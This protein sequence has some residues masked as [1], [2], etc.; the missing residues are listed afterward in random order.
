MTPVSPDKPAYGVLPNKFHQN[1]VA[2]VRDQAREKSLAITPRDDPEATTSKPTERGREPQGANADLEADYAE[3]AKG[4]EN[5]NRQ[6]GRDI[7][8][9][10]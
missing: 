8:D 6:K 2:A 3:N 10:N 9:D 1:I 4:S 7:T 5:K